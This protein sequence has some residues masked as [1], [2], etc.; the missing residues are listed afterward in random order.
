M[1]K[2]NNSN[3]NKMFYYLYAAI[4]QDTKILINHILIFF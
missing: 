2:H 3:I 1:L 4:K